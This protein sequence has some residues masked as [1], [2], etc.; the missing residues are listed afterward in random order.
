MWILLLWII[1]HLVFFYTNTGKAWLETSIGYG[2]K[3]PITKHMTDAHSTCTRRDHIFYLKV[4][5]TGS[6]TVATILYR[7]LFRH[8]LRIVP[9][10]GQI[11]PYSEIQEQVIQ[12]NQSE[13]SNSSYNIFLEHT[14]FNENELYKVLPRSTAK[15]A[16]IRHPLA[17]TKSLFNEMG[18]GKKLNIS[19]SEDPV[20]TYL[21]NPAKSNWTRIIKR[22]YEIFLRN[23]LSM[24]FGLTDRNFDN[25]QQIND[26]L[27]YI[28]ETF[29]LILISERMLESLV[30]LKR[31]MCLGIQ[32][33]IYL[34][35]RVKHYA[36]KDIV[37]PPDVL[38]LHVQMN[39]ADYALY[40]YFLAKHN[41]LIRKQK[42]FEEEVKVFAQII[43]QIN[44][45]CQPIKRAIHFPVNGSFQLTYNKSRHL[46]LHPGI[47]GQPFVIDDVDCAIMTSDTGHLRHIA[48]A[49][50]LP[51]MC[52]KLVE[53][54]LLSQASCSRL[55]TGHRISA[56][57]FDIV[58]FH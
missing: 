34:K 35:Q 38:Q 54:S 18:I 56:E 24:E 26:F 37:Y 14:V 3:L 5:K 31:L 1:F 41:Q 23:V 11:F 21:E 12:G 53:E 44:D 7:Y 16:S 29:D 19:D 50:Q 10:R 8:N 33:I 43:A 22:P 55:D 51:G 15:I 42:L 40:E 32:D 13:R 49:R 6:S 25:D 4:H 28:N 47:W 58:T 48:L 39:K 30:L 9:V 52:L 20:R 36:N 57:A 45:F 2:R 27:K 17:H 46:T